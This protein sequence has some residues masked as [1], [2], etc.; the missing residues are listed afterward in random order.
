[1][2]NKI[3]K[4][5]KKRL[6]K[7][8]EKVF[9]IKLFFSIIYIVVISILWLSAFLVYKQ[10]EE[11]ISLSNAVNI[12]QYSYVEIDLMSEKFAHYEQE[13]IS[14][15][16]VIDQHDTGL[17]H[18]YIIAVKDEDEEVYKDIIDYTYEITDKK[19]EAIT[20]YGYPT[21]ISSEIKELAIA[22]II[23]FVPKEN[24]VVI[25]EE[26]FEQYLT[27]SYLDTTLPKKDEFNLILFALA[28]LIFIIFFLFIYTLFGYNKIVEAVS[29][30]TDKIDKKVKKEVKKIFKVKKRKD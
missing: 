13:K 12:D 10:S 5:Y 2:I 23:N 27:N 16:F 7:K 14:L 6:S 28:L 3:K 20:V 22:N 9:T 11:D 29:N 30:K 21:I 24:E 25:T 17:W 1:M 18:T 4:M 8:N 15:H 26:N 19:P